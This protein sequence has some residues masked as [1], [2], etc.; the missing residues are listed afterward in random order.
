MNSPLFIFLAEMLLVA[1][2]VVLFARLSVPKAN[3]LTVAFR[4]VWRTFTRRSYF[5]FVAVGL[6]VVAVDLVLTALDPRWTQAVVRWRGDDYT[7]LVSAVEGGAVAWCQRVTPAG[8]TWFMA[9]AYLIAFPAMLLAAAVVFDHLN[10]RRRNISLLAGYVVNYLLVLPFYV[11]F[12]VVECHAYHR[13]EPVTRL[14]LNDISPAVIA[15][16]RPTSGI[17]NCFPSF[18]ASLAV[19]IALFAWQS[20][21]RSLGILMLATAALVIASTL[22]LGIHWLSDVGAGIL[23]GVLG[24]WI[25]DRLGTAAWRRWAR[26][27]SPQPLG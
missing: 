13:S 6:S 21:R 27:D 26:I 15:A 7:S 1:A 10:E 5:L 24:Y 2:T 22:Y 17:D 25:G 14:L 19:T 12:P 9:W 23:V 20:R 11:F 8:V 16:L 3:A 18:H 4:P